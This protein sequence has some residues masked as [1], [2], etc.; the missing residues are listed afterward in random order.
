MQY[1]VFKK[2]LAC[3]RDKP[4]ALKKIEKKQQ[5]FFKLKQCSVSYLIKEAVILASSV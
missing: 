4:G 5:P 1:A 2:L 3:K